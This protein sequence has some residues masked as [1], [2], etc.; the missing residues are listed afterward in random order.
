MTRPLTLAARAALVVDGKETRFGIS[1]L[2]LAVPRAHRLMRA[3]RRAW[4]RRF[5]TP[6]A[7]R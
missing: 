5:L 2:R 6:H 7:P 4:G 3:E 1:G